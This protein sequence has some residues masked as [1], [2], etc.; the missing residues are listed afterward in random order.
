MFAVVKTGGKQYVV[1]ENDILSIEKIEGEKGSTISLENI[2]LVAEG[3]DVSLGNP[4]V[5]GAK[6]DVEIVDQFKDKKVEIV[7]FKRKTGYRR[8][9]GHR[10]NLTKV[11][12]LKITN[13]K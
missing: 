13:G 11:K 12:I 10:Q 5:K 1:K 2:L 3:E 9:N 6:I 7:K 8:K 4:E